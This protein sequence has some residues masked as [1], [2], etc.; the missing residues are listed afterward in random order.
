M[1]KPREHDICQF[2]NLYSKDFA[3]IFQSLLRPPLILARSIRGQNKYLFKK[4]WNFNNYR[5]PIVWKQWKIDFFCV[6]YDWTAIKYFELFLKFAVQ[7]HKK[8]S[9]R[10]TNLFIFYIFLKKIT[11]KQLIFENDNFKVCQWFFS[12]FCTF[13]FLKFCFTKFLNKQLSD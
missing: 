8:F 9:F 7:Y 10:K 4:H 1:H 5:S 11:E 2:R 6:E 3:N 13:Y 12:F